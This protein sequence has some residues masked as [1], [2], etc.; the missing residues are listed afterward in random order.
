MAVA[1][2]RSVFSASRAAIP[3]AKELGKYFDDG[4]FPL[5]QKTMNHAP[6]ELFKPFQAEAE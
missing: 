4:L 6:Y 1:S 3:I 2:V 5:P